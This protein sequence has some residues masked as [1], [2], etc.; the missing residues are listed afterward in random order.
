MRSPHHIAGSSVLIEDTHEILLPAIE[1]REA[2]SRETDD[3][4]F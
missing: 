4:V 1:I 2:A 3:D